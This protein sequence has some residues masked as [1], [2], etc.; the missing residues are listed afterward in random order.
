MGTSGP[1][2]IPRQKPK[3]TG[4]VQVE[5]KLWNE[6]KCSIRFLHRLAWEKWN[7][8]KMPEGM[9]IDHL[10]RNRA[11]MNPNHLEA[12][13]PRENTLRSPTSPPAINARKTECKHG[14][15]L[16][17]TNTRVDQGKRS[18]R[19]CRCLSS[20]AYYAR[21]RKKEKITKLSREDVIAIRQELK[22]ATG[23]S[24]AAK[25]G[26]SE[27]LISAIVHGRVWRGVV[28]NV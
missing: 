20:M 24:I 7:G 25:Y 21:H 11:C 14:H 13:S 1:C 17:E 5:W 2:L 10:C 6:S 19:K 15:A 3:P 26:V 28:A 16:S 18:C 27:G 4:Y 12:V 9:Q 8:K 23:R 22:S